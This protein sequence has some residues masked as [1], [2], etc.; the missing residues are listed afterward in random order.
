MY[1]IVISEIV[2]SANFLYFAGRNPPST[3]VI[4]TNPFILSTAVFF[5]ITTKRHMKVIA[6][7]HV[8]TAEIQLLQDHDQALDLVRRLCNR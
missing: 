7:R 3:R 8:G 5:F 2:R 6:D 1:L 4:I